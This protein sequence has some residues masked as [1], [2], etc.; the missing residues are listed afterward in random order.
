M[1]ALLA[2]V[3]AYIGVGLLLTAGFSHAANPRRFRVLLAMQAMWPAWLIAPVVAMVILM[4]L[5]LG[6]TGLTA[7]AAPGW[8]TV[9]GVGQ[10]LTLLVASGM[11]LAFTLY[12]MALLIRRPGVPC[13]CSHAESPVNVWVPVRS[14]AAMFGCLYAVVFSDRIMPASITAD[15]LVT[16]LAAICFIVLLWSLPAALNDPYRRTST[17][18]PAPLSPT[19][20]PV[21]TTEARRWTS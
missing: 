17:R 19:A 21:P 13:A 15:S 10:G 20:T 6:V 4:E 9:P 1:S 14:L 8:V 16:A 2:T 7:V 12:S 5:A 11:Y 18:V 3:G